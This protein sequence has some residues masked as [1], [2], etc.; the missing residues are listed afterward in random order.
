[1]VSNTDLTNSP[2]G[3][4]EETPKIDERSN[5]LTLQSS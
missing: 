2:K 3:Q 1:M 4:H 5:S